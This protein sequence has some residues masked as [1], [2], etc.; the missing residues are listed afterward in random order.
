VHNLANTGVEW[1]QKETLGL[2]DHIDKMLPSDFN[3][4]C[5]YLPLSVTS[6]PG[7]IRFDVNPF[8]REIVDCFDVDSPVRDVTVKKGTQVTYTTILESVMLYY[9]FHVKTMPI[10][11]LTADKELAKAR[12]D[13]NIIP[14]I[15]Q[16]G[17]ED[18]IRSGDINNKRKTGK[19]ASMMQFA[20]GGYFVWFGVLNPAKMRT[21]AI[22][23]LLK[24]E[25]SGWPD[26]V[27]KDGCP[28][29]LTDQRA[30]SFPHTKKIFRGS[31]PL[32]EETCKIHRSYL[33]GDQRQY[34][35]RCL[36]CSYPQPLRWSGNNK[37][38][39]HDFGFYWETEN[40][41]LLQDSVSYRCR[42]CG[43]H[44]YEYDKELL[45]AT[46]Q[47]AHWKPT[48]P[49]PPDVRSYHLPAMYSPFGMR[50]W[51][52]CVSDYLEAYDPEKKVV[53]NMALFQNFYN[54]ILGEPFK[55]LGAKVHFE[56]VSAHRRTECK[57]G[58]IPNAFAEKWSESKILMLTCTVDVHKHNLAV[59]VIGWTKGQRSYLVDYW[60]FEDDSEEGCA[61]PESPVWGQL[62]KLIDE[63]EYVARDGTTYNIAITLIDSG[64]NNELVCN[65]CAEYETGVYPILGRERPAK[66]ARIVEFAKFDTQIGTRGFKITVDH[67]KDRIAPVLRREW[68][69]DAGVQGQYHFNAPVDATDDQLKELTR[70]TKSKKTDERGHVSWYWHRPDGVKNELWDLLVY[71]HAAVEIFAWSICI[72]HFELDTIDWNKFWDFIIEQE[73]TFTPKG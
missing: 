20:G 16:S 25:T 17:F 10:M 60:R 39:G 64:Y 37:K 19:T 72:E 23:I 69:K 24:D 43:H 2:T 33:R 35:V 46:D 18:Q 41:V 66:N 4:K 49:A 57:Y 63:K 13:A 15:N 38:T 34:M 21:F 8:A 27:G 71:A 51:A 5:R 12:V 52:N 54:N 1:L 67:Y 42:D 59:A 44:H 58:Q 70:E 7:Y 36:D 26:E 3:E 32:L 45:L 53:K 29:K 47:G 6:M 56:Q 14:M 40:G 22:P 28:D 31:S 9:M 55:Q 73:Y 61:R 68:N 11:Y 30:V 62:R 48:A 50:T 65:F